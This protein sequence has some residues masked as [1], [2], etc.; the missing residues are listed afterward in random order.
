MGRT[1]SQSRVRGVEEMA[2]M[3]SCSSGG[4]EV[5][6]AARRWADAAAV[7]DLARVTIEGSAFIDVAKDANM[8]S[9]IPPIDTPSLSFSPVRTSSGSDSQVL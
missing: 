2:M 3:S 6:M 4:S 8:V 9:S 1:S 5:K 7:M